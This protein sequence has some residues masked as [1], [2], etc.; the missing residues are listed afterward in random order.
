MKASLLEAMLDFPDQSGSYPWL[1]CQNFAAAS[2]ELPYF[3]DA[4]GL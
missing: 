3:P 1:E 4:R 2:N